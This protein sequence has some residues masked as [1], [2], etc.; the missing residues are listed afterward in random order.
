MTSE[1]VNQRLKNMRNVHIKYAMMSLLIYMH[2]KLDMQ[3][4]HIGWKMV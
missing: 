1:N 2:I 3:K 4:H